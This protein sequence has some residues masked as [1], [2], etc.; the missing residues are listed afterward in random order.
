M[1]PIVIN[2]ALII[3][4]IRNLKKKNLEENAPDTFILD[5]SVTGAEITSTNHDQYS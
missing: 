2:N 5:F 4:P 3:E 1:P